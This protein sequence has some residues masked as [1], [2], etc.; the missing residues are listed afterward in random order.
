MKTKYVTW[1]ELRVGIL[2]T[3]SVIILT[4]VVIIL[5]KQAN[6]FTRKYTLKTTLKRVEGLT[7]GAPVWLAGVEVGNVKEIRFKDISKGGMIEVELSINRDVMELIRQD[8]IALI[9]AKGLLGDKIVYITVGSK[10]KPIIEPGGMIRSEEFT[11]FA[12]VLEK[13][14]T[15]LAK[16]S[17]IS[18]KIDSVTA[19]LTKI[20]KKTNSVISKIDSGEGTL[21]KLVNDPEIYNNLKIAI[22]NLNFVT[23]ELNSDKGTLGRLL[24]DPTLFDRINSASTKMN[25]ILEK[26]ESGDGTLGKLAGDDELYKDLIVTT[27]SLKE[28]LED[29]KKN[30]KKYLTIKVF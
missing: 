23:A 11:D 24:K 26:L 13:L 4:V 6:V 2:V 16:L 8:S 29:I 9:T 15:G 12:T 1:S 30:P 5:G 22:R 3:M 18:E 25:S 21:G 17:E 14:S 27:R 7:T 19:E 10:E 28:L 20:S